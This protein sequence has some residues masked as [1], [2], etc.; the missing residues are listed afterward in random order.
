[1]STFEEI[2]SILDKI[3]FSHKEN[4]KKNATDEQLIKSGGEI[5]QT[6]NPDGPL[7]KDLVLCG[8]NLIKCFACS[9]EEAIE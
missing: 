7:I 2:C 4:L 8:Q 9:T 1:M 5:L 6:I 3:I